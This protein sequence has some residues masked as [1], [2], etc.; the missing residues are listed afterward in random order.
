[1]Q[2]IATIPIV[3]RPSPGDERIGER[4]SG[5]ARTGRGAAESR[6]EGCCMTTV[7]C[8]SAKGGSGTTVV[9]IALATMRGRVSEHGAL[10]VDLAGDCPSAMGL[11]EPTGPGIWDW[12]EAG[13]EVPV[14]ALGRLEV[15]V[16]DQVSLLTSGRGAIDGVARAGGLLDAL[17]A[18]PRDVVID[19]GR[20]V[21]ATGLVSEVAATIARGTDQS[22]LVT[23]P[24]FLSLRRA[25]ASPVRPTGIV[26]VSEEG[27]ALGRRE[28]EDIVGV[29]V[30]AEVPVDASVARAVDAGTLAMRM[31]RGLERWLRHAA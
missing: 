5:D 6:V 12:L 8:W 28:V 14:D 29:P 10:L 7:S 19:L 31:P 24:C 4:V 9:A 30:V 11:P 3:T 1:L 15:E 16:S 25:L 22:L 26:L 21:G 13:D 18:D 23:R 17:G 27:R 2:W 20:V